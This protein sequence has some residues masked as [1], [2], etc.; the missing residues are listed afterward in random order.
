M[1]NP[2]DEDRLGGSAGGVFAGALDEFAGLEAGAGERDPQIDAAAQSDAFPAGARS[3]GQ[4]RNHTDRGCD[5]VTDTAPRISGLAAV[6]RQVGDG[7]HSSG[8][9]RHRRERTGQVRVA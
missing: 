3:C 9:S 5:V 4:A 1:S 8:A 6:G 2:V 7:G